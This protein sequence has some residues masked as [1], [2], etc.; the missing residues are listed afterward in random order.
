M[1]KVAYRHGQYVMAIAFQVGKY[2][3]ELVSDNVRVEGLRKGQHVVYRRDRR[4]P[5]GSSE[6]RDPIIESRSIDVVG[7][8]TIRIIHPDSGYFGGESTHH[9]VDVIVQSRAD[10]DQCY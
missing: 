2:G 10:Q 1:R 8:R 7:I 6:I 3:R 5:S 4:Y 9:S